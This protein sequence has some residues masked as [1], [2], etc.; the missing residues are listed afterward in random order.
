MDDET[1]LI[2]CNRYFFLHKT[3]FNLSYYKKKSSCAKLE[4]PTLSSFKIKLAA[5]RNDLILQGEVER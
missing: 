4:I 1:K 3:S 2:T 5:K